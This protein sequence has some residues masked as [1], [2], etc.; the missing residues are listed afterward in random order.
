M[1]IEAV[2]QLWREVPGEKYHRNGEY[3]KES[4]RKR[5]K[6]GKG[7][8]N[9]LPVK[10]H[11]V[12]KRRLLLKCKCPIT[13]RF[14]KWWRFVYFRSETNNRIQFERENV[15]IFSSWV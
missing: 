3:I 9:S 12:S 6:S 10:F 13:P 7:G 1:K 8:K 15:R 2:Y 4:S 11:R 5:V 14:H